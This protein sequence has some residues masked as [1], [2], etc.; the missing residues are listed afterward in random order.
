M[1]LLIALLFLLILSPLACANKD[2]GK[3]AA[4]TSAEVT[5]T[6]PLSPQEMAARK[7]EGESVGFGVYSGPLKVGSGRLAYLGPSAFAKGAQP[8]PGAVNQAVDFTVSSF[9]VNDHEKILGTE[10]FAA[11][12]R[13]MRTIR[14]FGKNE[15]ITEEYASGARRVTISKSADKAAPEIS[16]IDSEKPMGNVLLL[17]YRLR[18][19]PQLAVGKTY[20]ITLPTATFRL[21]VK[22]KRTIKVPLGRFDAFYI[23]SDP[24]KYR[25]WLSAD[26]RR[27]PLRIQGLAGAGMAFLAAVSIDPPVSQ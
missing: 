12:V 18:C 20:D 23:E 4:A 11:P 13:V 24:P 22:D 2:A 6:T 9:S 26:N 15:D 25:I 7:L 17:V 16:V 27:I 10:D 19:D 21:V 1:T 8:G 3:A 14:V 5:K